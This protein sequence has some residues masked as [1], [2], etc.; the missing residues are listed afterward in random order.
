MIDRSATKDI[1]VVERG[2]GGSCKE[3]LV[4][5]LYRMLRDWERYLSFSSGGSFVE[6]AI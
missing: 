3:C 6:Q 2:G 5:N 4:L 1:S